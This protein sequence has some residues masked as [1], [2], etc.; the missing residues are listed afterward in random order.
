MQRIP[1]R[2]QAV[3]RVVIRTLKLLFWGILLQGYITTQLAPL[4][5]LSPNCLCLSTFVAERHL[6]QASRLK[7]PFLE[8][9]IEFNRSAMCCHI[10]VVTPMLQMNWLMELT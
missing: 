9:G 8:R 1:D 3:R 10:Q 7:F 6:G 2:G 4:F 5:F